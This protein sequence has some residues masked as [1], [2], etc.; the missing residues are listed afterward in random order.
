M[1]GVTLFGVLLTPVFFYVIQGLGETR[2][3]ASAVTQWSLSCGMGMAAGA[4]TGFL[5]GELGVFP[6]LWATLLGGAVGL[7]AV[8]FVLGMHHKRKRS[9]SVLEKAGER[10]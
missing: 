8:L 3:F 4:A 2:L 5:I 6:V 1:L 7:L 10:L 9:K